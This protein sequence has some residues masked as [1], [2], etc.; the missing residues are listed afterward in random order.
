MKADD[1]AT[2]IRVKHSKFIPIEVS[3]EEASKA[4]SKNPNF[5]KGSKWLISYFDLTKKTVILHKIII[6]RLR[7][8]VASKIDLSKFEVKLIWAILNEVS[9][10]L[11]HL[12]I[13]HMY[14][15]LLKDNGQLPYGALITR[16]FIYLN[17]DVPNNLCKTFVP[18]IYVG[19]KMLAM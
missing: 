5:S 6:N 4:A 2:N 13:L 14:I 9:F 3:K 17:I 8:K 16:I 7:P 1:L 15:I 12:I 10:S 19:E 11:L 18:L